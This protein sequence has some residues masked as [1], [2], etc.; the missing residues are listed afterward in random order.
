MKL[1]VSLMISILD[2]EYEHY[3]LSLQR[4]SKFKSYFWPKSN[5]VVRGIWKLD[6][7][8]LWLQVSCHFADPYCLPS[9]S[10]LSLTEVRVIGCWL[11][12]CSRSLIMANQKCQTVYQHF[13]ESG[14]CVTCKYCEKTYK[15][16]TA[17]ICG[18]ILKPSIKSC[19]KSPLNRPIQLWYL[20]PHLQKSEWDK[21]KEFHSSAKED[22]KSEL[23]NHIKQG[24]DLLLPL[25]NGLV[26]TGDTWQ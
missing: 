19:H 11:V 10:V 13:E 23:Q 8:G 7:R 1:I 20:I 25:A 4:F 21:V 9:A 2:Y 14:D 3:C 16:S 26:G 18:T 17:T 15:I 6:L 22:V 24:S 12:D 5:T